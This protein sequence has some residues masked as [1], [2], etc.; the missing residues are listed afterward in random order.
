VFL[1]VETLSLKKYERYPGNSGNA[2]GAKKVA[3]PAEKANERSAAELRAGV[4]SLSLAD[5][6]VISTR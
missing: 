6:L 4:I 5:R 3:T 2:H 1:S